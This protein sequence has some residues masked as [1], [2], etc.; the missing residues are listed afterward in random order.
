MFQVVKEAMLGNFSTKETEAG[1]MREAVNLRHIG[2][3]IKEFI[4]KAGKLYKEAKFSEELK[5]GII[6]EA[7]KSDQ[8]LIYFVR[9]RKTKTYEQVKEA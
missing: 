7:N 3:E 8:A 6:Q 4:V 2:D 5:F 1:T 9:L